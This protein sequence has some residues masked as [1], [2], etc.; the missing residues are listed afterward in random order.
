MKYGRCWPA[1]DTETTAIK[2]RWSAQN[3]KCLFG[4]DTLETERMTKAA[5]ALSC[6]VWPSRKVVD[7]PG[8][9]GLQRTLAAMD[10]PALSEEAPGRGRQMHESGI[11][12]YH[13]MPYGILRGLRYTLNTLRGLSSTGIESSMLPKSCLKLIEP[14]FTPGNTP[15]VVRLL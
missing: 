4:S 1:P 7:D 14:V 5:R 11:S 2:G 12:P 10:E 3:C 15:G 6:F 8:F 9:R 13:P